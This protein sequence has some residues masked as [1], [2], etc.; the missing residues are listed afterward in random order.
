MLE[1]LGYE[2]R[3]AVSSIEALDAFRTQPEAFDLV[4]NAYGLKIL[5]EMI[6]D[7]SLNQPEFAMYQGRRGHLFVA[8]AGLLPKVGE[9]LH[10]RLD[11]IVGVILS[12]GN[13]D[14]K[15]VSRFFT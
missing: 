8:G 9:I 15:L 4:I 2:V 14:L 10:I 12:G 5:R 1:S 3:A 7:N 6:S 11:F 13:V